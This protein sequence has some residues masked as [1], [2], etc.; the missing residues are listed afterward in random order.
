MAQLSVSKARETL[1]EI[2]NRVAYQGERVILQRHG[3]TVAALV[4]ASDLSRLAAL[5]SQSTPVS[6]ARGTRRR[7]NKTGFKRSNRV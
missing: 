7:R 3:R 5:D 4:S 1:S 2:V 6:T